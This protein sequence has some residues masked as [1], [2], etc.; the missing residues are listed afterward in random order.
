MSV[1]ERERIVAADKRHLWHPYTPMGRYIDE[2]NPLVVQRAEGARL[3]DHD[4]RSYIDANASWWTAVLGH[5]HPRLVR[6]LK[7]QIDRLCHVA[8]AGITHEP[9]AR[10]AEE[11]VQVTPPGLEHVFF[12]DDGSTAVESSLKLCVQYWA[13]NGAPERQHFLAL[14]GAFHGETLGAAALGGVEEFRRSVDDVLPRWVHLPSPAVDSSI[15]LDALD[16]ELS[17][18]GDRIAALVLEPL[19]QG[20]AGMRTYPAKYLEEARSLTR[21]HGVFLVLDEVFTGFGRTGPM[22]ASEHAS[23]APDVICLAKG[24]SG[25]MLPFAAIVA[26]RRIFDGFLGAPER[27]FYYGHTFCGNPLGAA[28]AREVLSVFRDEDVLTGVRERAE[29]IARGFA[30]L[31]ELPNVK[32]VRTLGMIGALD[33]EG[34]SGYLERGGWRVYNEALKRGAYLRPLGN[35]V[36]V[37]PALNIPLADLD[38]LLDIVH[39]AVRVVAS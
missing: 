35:V 23:V 3:F 14:E 34:E 33:L 12:S 26:S 25:G 24:L 1:P 20:A 8:L 18:R 22:W 28:V 39:D 36:Y 13:Q 31:A 4:G 27:A 30:R 10:L 17:Q 9:A 29:R 15:A 21:K 2:T 37:T 11:L 6:A 16:R 19:V 32:S 38:E 5:S 7:Q